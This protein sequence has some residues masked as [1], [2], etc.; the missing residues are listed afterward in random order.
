MGAKVSG[1]ITLGGVGYE[2]RVKTLVYLYCI[3]P[4]GAIVGTVYPTQRTMVTAISVL[5]SIG[6]TNK[7]AVHAVVHDVNIPLIGRNA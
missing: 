5:P 1:L 3:S 6:K 4:L 7:S 2:E